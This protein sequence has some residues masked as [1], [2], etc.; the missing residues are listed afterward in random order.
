MEGTLDIEDLC[1][2]CEDRSLEGPVDPVSL[3]VSDDV[4][5]RLSM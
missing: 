4:S 3:S 5:A 2:R 1:S